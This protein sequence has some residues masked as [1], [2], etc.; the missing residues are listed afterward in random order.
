VV[1]EVGCPFPEGYAPT[2]A[3]DI[4]VRQVFALPLHELQA[5]MDRL[6]AARE[7]GALSARVSYSLFVVHNL[8]R[9]RLEGVSED[10]IRRRAEQ[11]AEIFAA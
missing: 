8:I 3:A 1:A 7:S 9:R 6:D 11:F 2:L 5:E 10:E 4:V